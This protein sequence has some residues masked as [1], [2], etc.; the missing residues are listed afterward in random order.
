[1][2]DYI[3]NIKSTEN[4]TEEELEE[5]YNKFIELEKLYNKWLVNRD[6]IEGLEEGL[7]THKKYLDI[8]QEC[9]KVFNKKGKS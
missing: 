3:K 9:G 7:N 5:F 8:I 6:N 2:K 4:F 1:M